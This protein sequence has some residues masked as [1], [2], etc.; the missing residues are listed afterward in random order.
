MTPSQAFEN[1]LARSSDSFCLRGKL[2]QTY[3]SAATAIAVLNLTPSQLGV[4]AAALSGV[5]SR[6]RIKS[7]RIKFLPGAAVPV[8]LGVY[9]EGGTTEG[10][11]PTTQAG[12]LELRCSGSS[13]GDQTVPTEFMWKPADARLWYFTFGGSTGSDTRLV[14]SGV[15]YYGTSGTSTTV[16]VEIDYS[17]VYKGAVDIGSS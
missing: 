12:V 5:F 13:L 6:Y 1:S 8:A 14:N 10:G 16:N 7:L 2:L 15:L 17:I 4:R 3:S 11:A 9:D